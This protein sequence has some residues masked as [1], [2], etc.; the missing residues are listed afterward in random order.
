MLTSNSLKTQFLLLRMSQKLSLVRSIFSIKK[1]IGVVNFWRSCCVGWWSDDFGGYIHNLNFSCVKNISTSVHN[2]I[3]IWKPSGAYVLIIRS[4]SDDNLTIIWYS[5]F[6]YQI[7]MCLLSTD[8]MTTIWWLSVDYLIK[9]TFCWDSYDHLMTAD[10]MLSAISWTTWNRM[11]IIWDF[12]L[13]LWFWIWEMKVPQHGHP[14]YP[15]F[16]K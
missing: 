1:V 14:K 9:M 8:Q 10:D 12:L 3:V 7:S 5:Y 16:L 2:L 15:T 4:S 13:T 11:M 6:L